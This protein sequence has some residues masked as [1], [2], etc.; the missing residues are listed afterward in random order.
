MFTK[1]NILAALGVMSL[2]L[3]AQVASA[4]DNAKWASGNLGK[5]NNDSMGLLDDINRSSPP[6]YVH[7]GVATSSVT[8]NTSDAGYIE[9][10]TYANTGGGLTV[11]APHGGGVT[12]SA[13]TN[14][15]DAG[16]IESPT[17]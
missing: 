5:F 17:Y 16:Y 14:T 9:S 15:S 11:S 13:T 10:P 8:V 4:N 2:L 12:S 7:N 6:S 1:K 3:S